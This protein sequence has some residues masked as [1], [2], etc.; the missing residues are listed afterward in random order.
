ME[1]ATAASSFA[2]NKPMLALPSSSRTVTPIRCM[3]TSTSPVRTSL[4][5]SFVAP[6]AGICSAS[7][8]FSGH[9][10]RPSSLNPASFLGSNA[11]RGVVTMVRP[12]QLLLSARFAFAFS[13]LVSNWIRDWRLDANAVIVQN[14]IRREYSQLV[15]A[16]CD[17]FECEFIGFNA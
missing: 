6:Y 10:L 9:K 1:V 14:L 12:F 17:S 8:P 15:C 3:N 16:C 2:L 7:S 11:K 4:S 5:T 13:V